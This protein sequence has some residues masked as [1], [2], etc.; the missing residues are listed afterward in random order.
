MGKWGYV[1]MLTFTVIGSFWLE[2]AFRVRVLKRFKRAAIAIVPIAVAFL[3]WDA[4]AIAHH[5]WSFDPHQILGIIGPF[6]I[7]LEEYLFFLVVPLAA[8]MTIEAVRRVKPHW[9]IGDES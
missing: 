3:I 8:I 2:V 6:Q 7:P 5:D 1:A 4:L 9:H